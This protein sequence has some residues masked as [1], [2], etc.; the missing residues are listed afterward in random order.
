[1]LKLI[2]LSVV[3]LLSSL[4]ICDAYL[5]HTGTGDGCNLLYGGPDDTENYCYPISG[6]FIQVDGCHVTTWSGNNCQGISN[7]R[8]N[9]NVCM[10][11]DFLSFSVT[12]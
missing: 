3:L 9:N 7:L 4:H 10:R 2:L 6:R 5:V 12:C 1:M 11:V 8:P